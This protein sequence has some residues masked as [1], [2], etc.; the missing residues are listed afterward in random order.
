[1]F[2]ADSLPQSDIILY[3]FNVTDK[4]FEAEFNLTKRLDPLGYGSHYISNI[5]GSIYI[6]MLA[7]IVGLFSIL[8]FSVFRFGRRFQ[9]KLENFFL[10]NWVIR[11]FMEACL[12]LSFAVILNWPF[13]P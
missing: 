8:V 13:I 5:M 7:T 2:G 12:E 6:F 3:D 10:W 11:L 4:A 1:M 9:T